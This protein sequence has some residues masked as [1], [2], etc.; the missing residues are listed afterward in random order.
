MREKFYKNLNIP[1]K[2]F[3]I[4]LNYFLYLYMKFETFYKK[5][6]MEKQLKDIA[7]IKFGLY[8]KP[9]EKGFAKYLQAK[10]FDDFGNLQS[11]ID[12][13]I[14]IDNKKENHLLEDGDVANTE[15]ACD[16][17]TSGVYNI[18]LNFDYITNVVIFF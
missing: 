12:A 1:T 16:L 17:I 15:G 7:N 10:N 13:F 3:I 14:N 6:L 5:V 4:I 18:Y 11:D 8:V 2:I 9:L